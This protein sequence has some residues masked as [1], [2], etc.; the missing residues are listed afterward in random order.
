MDE[1]FIEQRSVKLRNSRSK[2]KKHGVWSRKKNCVDPFTD[3]NYLF[4]DLFFAKWLSK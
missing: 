2:I 4:E 3:G 1:I